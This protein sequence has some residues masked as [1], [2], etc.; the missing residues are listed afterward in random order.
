MV[1]AGSGPDVDKTLTSRKTPRLPPPRAS[2]PKHTNIGSPKRMSTGQRISQRQSLGL[3]HDGSPT[4][5]RTQPPANRVLD[6]GGDGVRK[7][8]ESPSPFK[9][10]HVL[11]RSMAG[12]DPFASPVKPASDAIVEVNEGVGKIDNDD[13]IQIAAD[14]PIMITDDDNFYDAMPHQASVEVEEADTRA[15]AEHKSPPKSRT[16]RP[17]KSND[18]ANSSQ[19]Q[20]CPSSA[21]RTSTKKRD[22]SVLDDNHAE[23]EQSLLDSQLSEL[24]PASKK[25]RGKQPKAKNKEVI[26]HHRDGWDETIDPALLAYGDQYEANSALEAALEPNN[27]KRKGK[28]KKGKGKAP[29]ERDPN[30]AMRAPGSPVK[31]NDSP[32]KLRNDRAGGRQSSIGPMNHYHLRA[33]TPFEDAGERTSRYGRNLIQPLKYWANEARIYR[34][35]EIEGI[36]RAE[37][38]ELPKPKRPKKKGRKRINKLEDI[39]EESETESVM[40]DEWEDEVGVIAGMVANWDPE[41]QMGVPEDLLREGNTQPNPTLPTITRKRPTHIQQKTN[42]MGKQISPSPQQA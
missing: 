7:S 29:K 9:P 31:L 13:E 25:P 16:A 11:R 32:S 27:S 40:A 41:T 24:G 8:I 5:P 21:K 20:H 19:I 23:G 42:T 22:L 38:V 10:R 1:F 30:R 18:T 4:R 37:E 17:R 2:T 34:R 3:E 33:T 39:D 15:G 12:K 26:I 36:V 14:V 6:F 28:G 35:G